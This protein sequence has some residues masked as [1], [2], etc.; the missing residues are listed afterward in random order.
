MQIYHFPTNAQWYFIA[1][2]D[3]QADL[4]LRSVHTHV[5]GFVI[6]KML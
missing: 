1:V 4:R 6:N 3:T 2:T 5:V